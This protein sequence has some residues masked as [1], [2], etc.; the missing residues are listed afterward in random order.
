MKDE[1][2]KVC[3]GNDY[4]IDKDNNVHQCPLCTALGKLYEPQEVPNEQTTKTIH[5]L[6]CKNVH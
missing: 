5:S 3:D 2:C 4:I 6:S 1:V